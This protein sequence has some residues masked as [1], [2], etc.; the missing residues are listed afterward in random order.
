M[1]VLLPLLLVLLI[2]TSTAPER[3]LEV[4]LGLRFE[5]VLLDPPYFVS[6]SSSMLLSPDGTTIFIPGRAVGH[7]ATTVFYVS[8]GLWGFSPGTGKFRKISPSEPDLYSEV[9]GT[10]IIGWAT[11]DGITV[12]FGERSYSIGGAWRAAFYPDG[13]LMVN[14]TSYFLIGPEPAEGRHGY[15]VAYPI[16]G[17][18]PALGG[19]VFRGRDFRGYMLFP[20]NGTVLGP[21][22]GGFRATLSLDGGTAVVVEKTDYWNKVGEIDL[23]VGGR[24]LLLLKNDPDAYFTPQACLLRGG[25][26]Y[27]VGDEAGRTVMLVVGVR[28]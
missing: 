4:G 26:L 15:S 9:D 17:P 3:R 19:L 11:S 16:P 23:V 14:N 2:L 7:N 1:R 28:D 25:R 24:S 22:L 21:V 18:A 13:V 27:M 5:G 10:S 8:H 6:I 20:G 12:T